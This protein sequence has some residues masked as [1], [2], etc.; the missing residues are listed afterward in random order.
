MFTDLD[1]EHF[2]TLTSGRLTNVD[3]W[4]SWSTRMKAFLRVH[5]WAKLIVPSYKEDIIL[6]TLSEVTDDDPRYKDLCDRTIKPA[7]VLSNE[8]LVAVHKCSWE[9]VSAVDVQYFYLTTDFDWPSDIW[10]ALATTF[11]PTENQVFRKMLELRWKGPVTT[12]NLESFLGER[13][14][15]CHEAYSV[16]INFEQLTGTQA[17]KQEIVRFLA[18]LPPDFSYFVNSVAQDLTKYKTVEQ[19]VTEFRHWARL[20]LA[21]RGV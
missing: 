10:T 13:G 17:T 21:I 4:P 12:S 6:N 8:E 1:F 18:K 2:S 3:D 19:V 20:H 9:L 15:I 5:R 14:R 16:G 7:K 11:Q